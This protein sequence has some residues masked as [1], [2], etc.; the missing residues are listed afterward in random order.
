MTDQEHLLCLLWE[1]PSLTQVELSKMMNRFRC[2]V[3]ILMCELLCEG[4]PSKNWFQKTVRM[5][6]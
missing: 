2:M 6:C 4:S 5:D 1:N 3:Q